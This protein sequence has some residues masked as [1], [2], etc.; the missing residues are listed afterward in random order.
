MIDYG[1]L[2]LLVSVIA[3]MCVT[4]G[5]DI[6]KSEY[7][8]ILWDQYSAPHNNCVKKCKRFLAGK[9]AQKY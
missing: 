4:V 1:T 6:G 7:I 8:Q 3:T 2:L 5:F 9:W